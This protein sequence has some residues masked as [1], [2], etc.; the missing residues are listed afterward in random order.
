MRI[1]KLSAT[2]VGLLATTLLTVPVHAASA[3]S[4]SDGPRERSEFQMPV[5]AGESLGA[6]AK[7]KKGQVLFRQRAVLTAA[8]RSDGMPQTTA[9]ALTLERATVT[10]AIGDKEH[11]VEAS[12]KLRAPAGDYSGISNVVE[13][14]L[15]HL[16]GS[17]CRVDPVDW[18]YLI[19]DD[20]T[21]FMNEHVDAPRKPWNC[22]VVLVVNPNAESVHD[23][24]VG[25]LTNQYRKPQLKIGAVSVLGK[26][27]KKRLRL[28][29]RAWTG[30][31]V[32]VR[33]TGT[34]PARAVRVTARGKRVKA[35]VAKG[36]VIEP[37]SKATVRI[38]I[39]P[40]R[41]NAGP[42]RIVAN[43]PGVRG[44]RKLRLRPT[45]VPQRPR[46]GR[47]RDPSN[48]VTFQVRNGRITRFR[49]NTRTRCGGVGGSIPTYTNNT[50]DFPRTKVG[51]NGIVDRVQRGKNDVWRWS[52]SLKMRVAGNK[53]TQ[54]R[55]QFYNAAGYC[56]ATETFTARR[57]G[58]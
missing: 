16:D 49:I 12:V 24:F 44:V 48:K 7:P 6:Y 39:R 27:Q 47:Y 35:K 42:I 28:V 18:T 20:G 3:A 50:Y 33:N 9:P 32:V 17:T 31:D 2:M 56:Q 10:V 53:V 51:K 34:V 57:V 29:R 19:N 8:N 58:K 25:R 45:P 37:K 15:G 4:Q 23:A 52:A 40:N 54:G 1:K 21:E 11:Y 26:N 46:N 55:F 41:N 43:R 5:P 36:V 38:R 13:L 22:V 14:A 30:V